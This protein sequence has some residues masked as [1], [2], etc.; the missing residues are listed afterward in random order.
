[1]FQRLSSPTSLTL[2]AVPVFLGLLYAAL[3]PLGVSSSTWLAFGAVLL[4]MAIVTFNTA[5]NAQPT[6]SLGQLLYETEHPRVKAAKKTRTVSK[7]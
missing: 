1:M 5:N 7:W 4:G 2:L 6:G 3:T